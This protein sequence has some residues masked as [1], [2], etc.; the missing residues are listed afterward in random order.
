MKYNQVIQF[1][2]INEVVKFSRTNDND[3]RQSLV[4]SFVF[5]KAYE[6]TLIPLICSNL[7][8]SSTN[9]TFG[10]QVVG[11]YGTGKSHLM[12]LISLIAEDAQLLDNVTNAKA[13]KDLSRIAGKYK[14]LR[15]ELGSDQSL[16]DVLAYRIEEA[17]KDLG[18]SFS[19]DGLDKLMYHERLQK[20]MGYFEEKFPTHGLMIVIDEMLAYLKGRSQP[21][22]INSDLQV[23][24]ALGQCSDH[25]KFRII[26]GVQELIYHSPEFQFAAQMLSKVKDRY[27]DITITK[28]DV[29]FVVKNRLLKKDE[30]QKQIIRKHLEPF[31]SLFA[32]MH[33]RIEEYVELFPVH[34]SYF[35]NFQLIKIG[36]S[37][38]EILKNLSLR[39]A[40]I[41]DTDVPEDNPGLITY[42]M[43]WQDMTSSQDLMAI[44]DVR[45][46]KEIMDTVFDKIST[47]FTGARA[48]KQNLA[49][50]IAAA[51]AVKI[52]QDELSRQ[53]GVNADSLVDDLCYTDLIA[54]ER[55]MLTDTINMVAKLIITATSG[56]YFDQNNDNGEFHLRIEGGVNYDQKI[57]D[58]AVLMSPAQKDE[59]FFQF[60]ALALPIEGNPYRS[61]F[62]IWTHDIEWKSHKTYRSGYIFM[63]NPAEKSTTQPRQHFYIYFMPIF[64][65]TKKSRNSEADEIYFIM[66]NLSDEFKNLI[67]LYGS[68][69]ALESSADTSQKPIYKQKCEDLRKKAMTAFDNSFVSSTQVEYGGTIKPMQGYPL[70]GRGASKEQ[71][72]D[73]IASSVFEKQFETENPHYPKF[74]QLLNAVTADNFDKYLKS[75]IQ[76]I[77]TP[78]QPNREGESILTGLGL[79]SPGMLDATQSIYARSLLKKLEDKGDGKV[80]NRDE[81]LECFWQEDN[82][83]ISTDFR[84]EAPY[85][86]LV[87][88]TLV[89][90]G[91]IEITLSSGKTINAANIGEIAK[92]DKQEMFQFSHIRRPKEVNI[93]AIREMFMQLLG[94]DLSKN[95]KDDST[96]I[97]LGEVISDYAKRAATAEHEVMGEKIAHGI[98]IFTSEEAMQFRHRLTAFKGFCDQLR[99]YNTEAIMKNFKF[100]LE[101]VKQVLEGKVILEQI[102]ERLK[103][104]H[105]FDEEIKYLRQALQYIP[106]GELFQAITL[107]MSKL[108]Q[109]LTNDDKK[110]TEIYRKELQQLHDQYATWYLQQ[111]LKYRISEVDEKQKQQLLASDQNAVCELLWDAEFI[112][113]SQYNEWLK[114]IHR[115]KVVDSKVNKAS[116]LQIPYQD[117]NPMEYQ[118]ISIYSLPEL[119]DD[120][121]SIYYA[122]DLSLKS[123][124]E[125]PSVTKNRSA[126]KNED[127]QL[128]VNYQEEIITLN[129]GNVA[130]IRKLITALHKG[131]SK[132]DI[133]TEQL[134]QTF[135][136]PMT[137]DEAIDAF[138]AFV[139]NLSKGKERDNVR[140]ILK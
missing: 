1:E 24:Q 18:I 64:D 10:L 130:Q 53:N 54:D 32:N 13:Q 14:V 82:L 116:I 77:V 108:P 117:F 31:T 19:F 125:D 122:F 11:S 94:R 110:L 126:L 73:A 76:K 93:A 68:A 128:L 112:S 79:W 42:D 66:D 86:F 106:Q 33:A 121:M 62:K 98:T 102:E 8:Y 60:L 27:R 127:Q 119:K 56:Q 109:V 92:L 30:H 124:L 20:M 105:G 35:E 40:Q 6:E 134:R 15:F 61:G 43:Y 3:Y 46:V 100:S 50:R 75:S 81:I 133:T 74:T 103:I 85:E 84:I 29:S 132:V 67:T 51:A 90:L 140:I 123:V 69:M 45:K 23:L 101:E 26:F 114:K 55:D 22:L 58:Y 107:G 59:Y 48:S 138:K 65:D 131:F 113:G 47:N 80:V 115:M 7:D 87:M 21:H 129:R 41:I 137:P 135:N 136:R 2:P 5:S 36:K 120:L 49:K 63:G 44:P 89:A 118:G 111:Y 71:M 99:N 88:S 104:I 52:L 72:V 95:L 25:S 83:W 28:E 70:P 97:A 38:R 4:K 9:E 17:L 57:K 12:S 96:Y 139:E 37:Q 39:F 78:Q 16:W 34:P 91:E